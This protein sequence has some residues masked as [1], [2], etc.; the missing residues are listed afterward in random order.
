MKISFTERV[1]GSGVLLITSW[2]G[3]QWC[4]V[5]A[6]HKP[7]N[8]AKVKKRMAEAARRPGAPRNGKR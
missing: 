3:D 7:E 5:A 4:N 8:I 2:D 1:F 6:L